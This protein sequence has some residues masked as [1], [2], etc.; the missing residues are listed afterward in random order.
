MSGVASVKYHSVSR[1]E[2][3]QA[4]IGAIGAAKRVAE[5]ALRAGTRQSN[6]HTSN[7]ESAAENHSRGSMPTCLAHWQIII[8]FIYY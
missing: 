1:L 2:G 4:A 7:A 5:I 8:K 3:R 6:A